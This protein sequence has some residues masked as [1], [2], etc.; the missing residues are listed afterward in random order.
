V[1]CTPSLDLVLVVASLIALLDAQPYGVTGALL[2]S[3]AI[4][5]VVVGSMLGTV[6]RTYAQVEFASD[7]GARRPVSGIER[8]GR[9]R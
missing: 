8:W 7:A 9:V 5:L 4:L 1:S 3:G 2:L 6:R